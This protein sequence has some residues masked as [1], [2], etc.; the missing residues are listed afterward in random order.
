VS[1]KDKLL[2]SLKNNPKNVN[3]EDLK[4]LLE[5]NGYS[6]ENSG[7][8]HWVFRKENYESITIPYKRPIKAIYVKRVL[9]ILE[10]TDD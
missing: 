9:L 6:A 10:E 7:G 2:L 8:S 1:R 5:D 3:F 4:K